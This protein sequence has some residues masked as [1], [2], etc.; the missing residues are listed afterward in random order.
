M[1]RSNFS[2]TRRCIILTIAWG[3]FAVLGCNDLTF[4]AANCQCPHLL[5]VIPVFEALAAE[6]LTSDRSVVFV[7]DDTDYDA[8]GAPPPPGVDEFGEL[9]AR[10]SE[11]LGLRTHPDEEA[12][13]SHPDV[14]VLTPVDPETGEWG[15]TLWVDLQHCEDGTA[16]VVAGYVRSGL[17]GRI[18]SLT[19][20]CDFD[21][22][23]IVSASP[24]GIARPVPSR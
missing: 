1:T 9:L 15:V 13:R 20:Q 8:E 18:F 5:D 16:E 3:T 2:C 22:W 17:D 19:L 24:I 10:L 23:Y 7:A 12:D 6:A 4:T 14:P 21:G 11:V